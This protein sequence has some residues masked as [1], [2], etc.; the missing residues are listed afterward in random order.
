MERYGVFRSAAAPATTRHQERAVPRRPRITGHRQRQSSP[1]RR[2]L[3]NRSAMRLVRLTAVLLFLLL[4]LPPHAARRTPQKGK[5]SGAKAKREAKKAG[6]S[7]KLAQEQLWAQEDEA[8]PAYNSALDHEDAQDFAAAEQ[9]YGDAIAVAPAWIA[10][11][12]NRAVL[13]NRLRRTKEAIAQ[14]EDLLK[15]HQNHT[16]AMFNLA[17]AHRAND[18]LDKA[19]KLYKRVI[20]KAWGAA[21]SEAGKEVETNVLPSASTNLGNILQ[22]QGHYEEAV[23]QHRVAFNLSPDTPDAAFN[24]GGKHSHY[25][26]LTLLSHL[27]WGSDSS[28]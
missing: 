22:K 26:S 3:H 19:V 15:I 28:C 24:L 16:E 18:E 9:A 27:F 13:L 23:G 8:M 1:Y 17:N 21:G 11:A 20:V 25:F 14:Y 10:P 5:G 4:L 7:S 6:V 2:Q 12:M